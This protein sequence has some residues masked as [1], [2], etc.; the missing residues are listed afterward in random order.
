MATGGNIPSMIIP[1]TAA[2][3]DTGTGT[4]PCLTGIAGIGTRAPGT[5]ISGIMTGS[6]TTGTILHGIT[7]G[8][9]QEYG[10]S[11]PMDIMI[12]TGITGTTGGI[13]VTVGITV[14]T[15]GRI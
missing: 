11:I 6:T 13:T 4:C 8:H 12:S 3:T 2:G 1:G 15:E 9:T 14:T 10:A 7:C 5:G